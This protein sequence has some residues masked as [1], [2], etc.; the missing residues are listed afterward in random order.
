MVSSLTYF[1]LCESEFESY[2]E[3]IEVPDGALDQ[4]NRHEVCTLFSNEVIIQM[5]KVLAI[6][7]AS[8]LAPIFERNGI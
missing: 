6:P 1:L 5:Y 3:C 4:Q 2:L 8:Y 7:C